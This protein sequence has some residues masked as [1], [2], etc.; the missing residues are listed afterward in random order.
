LVTH[1]VSARFGLATSWVNCER[2]VPGSS[3]RAVDRDGRGVDVDD[4]LAVPLDHEAA[5]AG[6]LAEHAG[7][8]IPFADHLEECVELVGSDD[9]HHALLTLAHEDLL[10]RECGVSQQHLLEVDAH[11]AAAVRGQF[12]RR[13]RDARGAEVLDRLDQA[14]AIQL[15]AAL[16]EHLLGEGV[17]DLH[18]GA[19]GRAGGVE[20]VG[21]Q[22]AG[23]A[24]AVATG[25]GAEQHHSVARAARV[26]EL[27]V[28]VSHHADREGVH[29]RVALVDR[30]EH[31]LAADVGKAE[32]VAVERDAGDHTVHD[33]R[34]VGVVDRAEAQLVHDSDRAGAHRDDVADDSAD[35]GRRALE[36][37]DVARV[38][39]RLDLEGHRPALADV[40][41]TGVLAHADHEAGLHL[42]GD[43]LAELAEVDLARLVRAVLRPHHRVH[44][45]LAARG[46]PPE[47]LAD[48]RVLVGLEAQR[49]VGLLPVGRRG[50]V[51]D[52]IGHGAAVDDLGG[53]GHAAQLQESGTPDRFSLVG[54]RGCSRWARQRVDPA[55]STCGRSLAEEERRMQ[56]VRR[57]G[58][59]RPRTRPRRAS[60]T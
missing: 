38:V 40:D 4:D 1:D 5:V 48:S 54:P 18:R 33:A 43:L 20:R 21:G 49:A 34:G 50:G 45:Q 22:D 29:E 59:A 7:L 35:A 53:G 26:R 42:V 30:I 13:A 17:A 60:R 36:R 19:L 27:E 23:P 51:L 25:A 10:G 12:A 2:R 52:G 9:R 32:A 16:D 55:V 3:E 11:S 58:R 15:E 44:R 14:V 24:D 47:D 8:D 56:G 28:L 31:G 57:R 37:L 46:A 41:H 6:H 39:V